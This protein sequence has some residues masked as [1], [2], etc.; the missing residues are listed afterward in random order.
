MFVGWRVFYWLSWTETSSFQLCRFKGNIYFL[1]FSDRNNI[2][3]TIL[4]WKL[5]R[6]GF[7]QFGFQNLKNGYSNQSIGTFVTKAFKIILRNQ[8]LLSTRINLFVC[9]EN[10]NVT[11]RASFKMR[12]DLTLLFLRIQTE[13]VASKNFGIEWNHEWNSFN[14]VCHSH[15]KWLRTTCQ[16]VET[17][18][19]NKALTFDRRSTRSMSQD[20]QDN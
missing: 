10:F 14:W 20:L 16:T 15:A 13:Y 12:Y 11:K 4:F 1:F 9:D 19:G 18:G 3:L 2:L 7:A 6:K 5:L 8:I 17:I